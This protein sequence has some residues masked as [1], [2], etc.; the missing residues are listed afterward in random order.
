[1]NC[2]AWKKRLQRTASWWN[3]T[4]FD[5]MGCKVRHELQSAPGITKCDRKK[6]RDGTKPPAHIHCLI[7][8][9]FQDL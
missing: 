4:K 2:K 6:K 9:L 7:V 1:M 5:R 3:L 8:K